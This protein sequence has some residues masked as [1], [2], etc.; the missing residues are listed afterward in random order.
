M[1]RYEKVCTR[2]VRQVGKEEGMQK[3]F[4]SPTPPSLQPAFDPDVVGFGNILLKPEPGPTVVLHLQYAMPS[5]RL[6]REQSQRLKAIID[7]LLEPL[8]EG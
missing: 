8:S 5:E 4:A 3:T 6:D 1:S 2:T 7:G